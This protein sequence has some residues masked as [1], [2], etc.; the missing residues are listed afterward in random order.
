M[1][2]ESSTFF[3]LPELVSIDFCT[4]DEPDTTSCEDQSHQADETSSVTSQDSSIRSSVSNKRP[5]KEEVFQLTGSIYDME[6]MLSE[7]KYF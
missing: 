4:V 5:H 7:D 6:D 3:Q 2:S 1:S